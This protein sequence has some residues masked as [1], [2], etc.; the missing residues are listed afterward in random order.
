MIYEMR[1]YEATP[2]KMAALN[3]V[4][5][6]LA[7]P[8]FE[9]VGMRLVGAWTPVAGDYTNALSY[10][11]AWES[12]NEREEKWQ[13]F[14][15]HPRLARRTRRCRQEARRDRLPGV[16]HLPRPDLLLP[17]PV[18]LSLNRTLTQLRKGMGEES[19]PLS[20]DGRGLG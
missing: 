6:S 7:V 10:M 18:N 1:R 12:L 17:P 2:G 11:L 14:F 3:E 5:E 4:M 9:K 13:E 19:Y 8:V 16:P 20:L 15:N